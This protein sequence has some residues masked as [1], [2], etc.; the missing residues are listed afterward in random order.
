MDRSARPEAP[1]WW[2]FGQALL[3][4]SFLVMVG[5]GLLRGDQQLKNSDWP[6]F[7]VAGR[8]VATQ[9]HQLYDREA[10]RREQRVVVGPG[11]YELPGYGG[12]LP[13]V[14]PP[15]VALY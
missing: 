2:D 6:S 4:A 1:P 11:S 5:L 9:P 3:V 12:L 15:W 13:V 8:L 10:E 14:A 7:M